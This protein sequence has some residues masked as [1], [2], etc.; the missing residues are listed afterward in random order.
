MQRVEL[1]VEMQEELGITVPESAISEV[2][3][4]RELVDLVLGAAPPGSTA[5]RGDNAGISRAG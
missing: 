4:V 3:T 1:L 5:L 2:Y